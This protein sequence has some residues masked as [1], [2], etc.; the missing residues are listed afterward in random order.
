MRHPARIL[1]AVVILV[2]A[3]TGESSDDVEVDLNTAVVR[4]A[5]GGPNGESVSLPTASSPTTASSTPS[6]RDTA[7]PSNPVPTSTSP[8]PAPTTA[9]STTAVITTATS[10]TVAPPTPC[11]DFDPSSVVVVIDGETWRLQGSGPGGAIASEPLPLE[12]LEPWVLGAVQLDNDDQAELLVAFGDNPAA[13]LIAVYDTAGCRL[14]EPLDVVSG[15]PIRLLVGVAGDRAGAVACDGQELIA[16]TV[17]RSEPVDAEGQTQV[18]WVGESWV[19]SLF[20]GSWERSGPVP[21]TLGEG[22][23]AATVGLHCLL[24]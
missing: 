21:V 3:C 16:T 5:G 10:T 24:E 19:L 2:A 1:F 17:T 7:Q 15:Q 6:E 18:R 9:P 13:P 11:A 23:L 20:S 22:Q 8:E 12:V 4:R 14:I